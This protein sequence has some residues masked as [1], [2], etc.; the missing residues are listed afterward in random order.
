MRLPILVSLVFLFGLSS[1]CQKDQNE[2]AISPTTPPS[3]PNRSLDELDTAEPLKTTKSYSNF[4]FEQ[5]QEWLINHYLDSNAGI[6]GSKSFS[7]SFTSHWCASGSTC[8]D[9]VVMVHLNSVGKCTGVLVAKK[10]VLTNRHCVEG[11]ISTPNTSFQDRSIMVSVPSSKKNTPELNISY[12]VNVIGLSPTEF[13]SDNTKPDYAFLLL[14]EPL[15]KVQPVKMN[16]GGI[17]EGE[18]YTIWGLSP[19]GMAAP[20]PNAIEKRN[21]IATYNMTV[22]PNFDSHL[23]PMVKFPDCPIG[24]SNSGS[25]IFNKDGELVG[26]IGGNLSPKIIQALET[27]G[28]INLNVMNMDSRLTNVAWGTNLAC[29]PNINELS[30]SI[31]KECD[32]A[33]NSSKK[34]VQISNI[35][36]QKVLATLINIP[37]KDMKFS[38]SIQRSNESGGISKLVSQSIFLPVPICIERAELAT[39]FGDQSVTVTQSYSALMLREN[40]TLSDDTVGP[41]TGEFT[42]VYNAD[43]LRTKKSTRVKVSKDQFPI[44]SGILKICI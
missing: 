7:T 28:K 1:A 44:Y 17:H 19:Y 6:E 12:V 23:S 18:L 33:F 11:I 16:F 22:A 14:M 36:E 21:C 38:Y 9:R 40:W 31:P 32:E 13:S 15:E 27:I 41:M 5:Q 43:E 10:V 26:L 24:P 34:L 20:D 3:A 30:K 4:M 35:K 42:Y 8:R 39:K 37:L 25:P 2:I 29:I